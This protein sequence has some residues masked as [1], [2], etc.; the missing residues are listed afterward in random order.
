MQ[1]DILVTCA[2]CSQSDKISF[3][4]SDGN[5]LSF[6]WDCRHCGCR[7]HSKCQKNPYT[8]KVSPKKE[9]VVSQPT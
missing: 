4:N 6:Y 3:S 7:N 9:K 2:G 8:G 5:G 1:E